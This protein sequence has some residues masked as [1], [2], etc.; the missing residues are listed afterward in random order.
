MYEARSEGEQ[1]Q[2]EMWVLGCQQIQSPTKQLTPCHINLTAHISQMCAFVT[3]NCSE[4]LRRYLRDAEL[5]CQLCEC[6]KVLS[7]TLGQ[8]H[9]SSPGSHHQL[10]TPPLSPQSYLF[11]F[12]F[13]RLSMFTEPQGIC[14]CHFLCFEHPSMRS[15]HDWISGAVQ[16]PFP[17]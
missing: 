2:A 9:S 7:C 1:K 17:P 4:T 13:L 8:T 14:T 11:P 16:V 3:E 15:L 6:P 12:L 5:N 10:H